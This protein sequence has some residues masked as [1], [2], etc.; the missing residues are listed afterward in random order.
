MAA[1]KNAK[2][3]KTLEIRSEPSEDQ[4]RARAYEI[5]L[6]RKGGPGDE[7]SDWLKAEAELRKGP[8]IFQ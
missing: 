7:L 6:A 5:Y 4:I 3:Q 8:T 2:E 1:K